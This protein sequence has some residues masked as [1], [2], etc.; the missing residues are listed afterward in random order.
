MAIS[1]VGVNGLSTSG[2]SASA[3]TT[4]TVPYAQ[5]PTS[6]VLQVVNVSFTN[7]QQTSSSSLVDIAGATISI[8]PKF[9]TS[10]I[11]IIVN[12]VGL[13]KNSGVN[14]TGTLKLLR[15]S[16]GVVSWDDF[17]GYTGST[18]TWSGQSNLNYLDSPATTSLITYKI[19]YAMTAGAVFQVNNYNGIIGSSTSTITAMEIAG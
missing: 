7:Y 19:Q 9:A 18:A 16:T 6:S 11:L 2:L 5:L 10:K 1:T 12:L 3:L 8:T 4:G 14:G 13:T 17:V 15:G